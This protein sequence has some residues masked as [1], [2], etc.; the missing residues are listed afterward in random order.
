MFSSGAGD[1]S[2][3]IQ[4]SSTNPEYWVNGSGN[5]VA[6]VGFGPGR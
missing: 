3:F 5:G 1:L 4:A 6:V 2:G